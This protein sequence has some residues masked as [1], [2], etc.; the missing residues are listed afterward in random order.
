MTT[1]EPKTNGR[2]T[3]PGTTR[4]LPATRLCTA[5]P[6]RSLAQAV[7]AAVRAVDGNALRAVAPLEA[8]LAS[9]PK[10]PAIPKLR[11]ARSPVR[12]QGMISSRWLPPLIAR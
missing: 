11:P 4:H 6:P 1:L 9:Q 2:N 10:S 5:A 7:E 8:G 3:R 12:L